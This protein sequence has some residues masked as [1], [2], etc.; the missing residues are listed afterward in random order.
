[1]SYMTIASYVSRY[2][3][4]NITEYQKKGMN[5][6]VKLYFIQAGRTNHLANVS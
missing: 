3:V 6:I 5:C 2:T 4:A 1:M